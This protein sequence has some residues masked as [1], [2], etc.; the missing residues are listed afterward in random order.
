MRRGAP[1]ACTKHLDVGHVTVD[2]DEPDITAV[3]GDRRPDTV[4]GTV[5]ALLELG[6]CSR[7]WP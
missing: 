1:A 3:G 2:A 7:Y 5:D 6:E 4:E